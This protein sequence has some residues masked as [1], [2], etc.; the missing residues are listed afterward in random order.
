MSRGENLLTQLKVDRL[1]NWRQARSPEAW[2]PGATAKRGNSF[3]IC[4]LDVLWIDDDLRVIEASRCRL[5]AARIRPQH[6][7][8]GAAGLRRLA[9]ERFDL[10]ILDEQMPIMGGLDVLRLLRQNGCSV[11]IMFLTAYP[12]AVHA[13]EV[14][15]LRAAGYYCKPLV[16]ELLVAAIRRSCGLEDGVSQAMD[17]GA[18]SLRRD[19]YRRWAD[20]MALAVSATRD[21]HSVLAWSQVAHVSLGTAKNWCQTAGLSARRSLILAR[22][23]RALLLSETIGGSPETFLDIADSRTVKRLWLVAGVDIRMADSASVL[24]RQTLI[25]DSQAIEELTR[26]LRVGGV[27][28]RS[29][30]REG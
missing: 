19:L 11:P 25:A 15:S 29:W 13:F 20:L 22:I 27:V 6:A 3:G 28:S 24:Q 18:R 21:P 26:R 23:L 17:V 8:D 10:I 30:P 14:G 1:R 9:E 2:Q 7:P 16:G 12:E 5:E 4:G